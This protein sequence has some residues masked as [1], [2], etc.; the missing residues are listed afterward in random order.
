[1]KNFCLYCFHFDCIE[2]KNQRILTMTKTTCEIIFE[3]KNTN[4]VY[5]ASE[6][7]KGNVTITLHKEKIIKGMTNA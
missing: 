6:I 4:D 7:V 5:Y 3:S 2:V 1:M